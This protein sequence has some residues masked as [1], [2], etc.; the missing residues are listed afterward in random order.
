MLVK[1]IT[2]MMM[3][4][5]LM[6]VVMVLAITAWTAQKNNQRA[7]EDSLLMVRGGFDA[8]AHN[9]ETLNYD[10]SS[11]TA[12]MENA[13]K[14]DV[15][16]LYENMGTGANGV[17]IHVL[18][19]FWPSDWSSLTWT[20]A[21]NESEA[22][23]LKTPKIPL[24]VV[25]SI[26]GRLQTFDLGQQ[27]TQNF[28]FNDGD[29]FYLVS[30]SRL[31]PFEGEAPVPDDQLPVVVMA[32]LLSEETLNGLASTFLIRDLALAISPP[33]MD[34]PSIPIIDVDGQI[35]A[36]LQWTPPRPGDELVRIAA[37]PISIGLILF[38]SLSGTVT[39]LA[40]RNAADLVVREKEAS[41]AART[42]TMTGLPNRMAFNEALA[43]LSKAD[44]RLAVLF[45][46]LNGF[47]AINDE[48][49]HEIGDKILQEI[50]SLAVN[51]KRIRI[52][53]R[54]WVAMNLTSSSPET[55]QNKY[56]LSF[57]KV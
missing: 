44:T 31:Q 48:Y 46:D 30:A 43:D 9:V 23:P 14:R 24:D 5:M 10:Y 1:K 39:L 33:A 38:L 49:G 26:H 20:V 17:A 7:A 6:S 41:S 22:E 51:L 8:L 36:H 45:M 29:E 25:Q 15:D 27:D 37:L 3:S 54:D 57:A 4:A 19:I 55:M 47:K 52:L 11:W 34:Q 40:K 13:L 2:W 50:A 16:W 21:V 12:A 35:I 18:E 42:D 56:A 28:A 53:L 32:Y